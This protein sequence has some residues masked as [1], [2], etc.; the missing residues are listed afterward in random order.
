[1]NEYNDARLRHLRSVSLRNLYLSYDLQ[2]VGKDNSN[3]SPKS[4]LPRNSRKDEAGRRRSIIQG[5][6][7]LEAGNY[8]ELLATNN[9][10]L[11]DCFFTLHL[12]GSRHNKR[13]DNNDQLIYV[14]EVRHENMN[15]NFATITLPYI[16]QL[17]DPTKV[18]I[19]VW[20]RPVFEK[21]KSNT[22][23]EWHLLSQTRVDLTKLVY[24]GQ[25]LD[26]TEDFFRTNSIILNLN[27]RAY[28]LPNSL[29]V[30]VAK[31]RNFSKT[32]RSNTSERIIGKS[33]SFDTL[34]ALN[35]LSL[36]L[37]ELLESKHKLE[38]QIKHNIENLYNPSHM[39]NIK[40][41]VDKLKLQNDILEKSMEKQQ[42]I[43]DELSSEIFK[44]KTRIN[45]L[46]TILD[47]KADDMFKLGSNQLELLQIEMEPIRGSLV[48]N[49]YP[50]II[51]E[52]QI[53]TKIVQ[54]IIQIDNI[55]NTVKFSIM[56]IEFPSSIKE[57]L[58]I[59]Y[60]DRAPLRNLNY[61]PTFESEVERKNFNIE[62][63]NAGLGFIIQM[64]STLALITNS[65]LK[66]KMVFLG[67]RSI[68]LDP[69]SNP[70]P[71]NEQIRSQ[72]G[73]P[74]T[75]D[76]EAHAYSLHYDPKKTEKLPGDYVEPS[77]RDQSPPRKYK[78]RN[79]TFEHGL[80]LLNK[81]LLLLINNVTDVYN[82][83]YHDNKEHHKISNNIPIDCLD[84][85]LWNLQYL[86]L[87]I[88]A[89]IEK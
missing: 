5:L 69:I 19:K 36:S 56:G 77:G 13:D 43:N 18:E 66:Y 30:P 75:D 10:K 44:I 59:C 57:L 74:L 38:N 21:L 37:N 35:S 61:S 41:D 72:K 23:T 2:G 11:L 49:I 40:M 6:P 85:F 15:P 46:T 73:V 48:G 86:I 24:V 67:N 55:G 34:R 87:F 17:A 50:S 71:T 81:N 32:H 64:I 1:M 33:Y 62:S 65:N 89:P 88:T 52:L 39:D 45:K 54:E 29:R 82:E 68:I 7:P 51:Q 84:N 47:E 28:V 26:N 3:N 25:S 70:T 16:A 83:F 78:L 22:G 42:Q 20:C 27:G 4:I 53:I 80:N 12:P 63:I 60:Y 58:D 14:S 8:S 79:A 9:R 31:L 76:N